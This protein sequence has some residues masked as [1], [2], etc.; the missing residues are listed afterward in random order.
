MKYALVNE[1]SGVVKNILAWDGVCEYAVA[2]GHILV[3]VA[4]NAMIGGT[5]L[6]G[7]FTAKAEG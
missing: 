4:D 2:P 1:T 5:Y 7:V 6:A 3:P